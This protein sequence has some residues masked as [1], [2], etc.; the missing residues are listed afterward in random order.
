MAIF[1]LQC[2]SCDQQKGFKV[3]WMYNLALVNKFCQ[4]LIISIIEP[5][6]FPSQ[7]G[8]N[9]GRKPKTNQPTKN[10]NNNNN[11]HHHDHNN[12]NKKHCHL[13]HLFAAVVIFAQK[14]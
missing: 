10:S 2:Q 1:T 3:Q 11:H 5:V 7:T 6:P 8:R 4:L 12:N 14:G 9:S 13:G